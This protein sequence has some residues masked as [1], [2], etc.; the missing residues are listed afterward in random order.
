MKIFKFP[1]KWLTA[2]TGIHG[3]TMNVELSELGDSNILG[4]AETMKGLVDGMPGA[5]A[6][7]AN[8]VGLPWRF[9]V[10]SSK[11]SKEYGLP[12]L[13]MNPVIKE[14]G[15]GKVFMEEGCLSF[16]GIYLNISR[17][18]AITCEFYTEE[19]K[20]QLFLEDFP[21]RMIQHECEHLDGEVFTKNVDRIT[22]FQIEGKMR[23]GR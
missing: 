19:G 13:F 18:E 8:Q 11:V 2:P 15:S 7:A 23:K 6:V 5:A 14:F 17:P 16:P 12:R 10:V 21:A 9:F 22:R 20:K 4:L 3:P 1:S